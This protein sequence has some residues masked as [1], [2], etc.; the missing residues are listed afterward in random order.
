M[1]ERKSAYKNRTNTLSFYVY[2]Y[3]YVFMFDKKSPVNPVSESR[4][5]P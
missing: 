3:V 1:R 2:V 5:V 4:G